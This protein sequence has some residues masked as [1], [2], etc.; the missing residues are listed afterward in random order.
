MWV[1]IQE[2]TS[3]KELEETSKSGLGT[4]SMHEL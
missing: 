3:Q 4:G 2:L 1:L